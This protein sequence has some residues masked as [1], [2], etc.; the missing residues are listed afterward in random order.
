M[1][2]GAGR[3]AKGNAPGF[4]QGRDATA[5][6]GWQPQR[7]PEF[8]GVRGDLG[9]SGVVSCQQNK[10]PAVVS[11]PSLQHS[12]PLLRCARASESRLIRLSGR[13]PDCP[14]DP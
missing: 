10:T 12:S 6:F 11:S 1:K 14:I 2:F 8:G 4:D 9:C 3:F 5:I 13:W 7:R